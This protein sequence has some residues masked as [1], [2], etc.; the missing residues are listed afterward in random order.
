MQAVCSSVACKQSSYIALYRQHERAQTW[1]D[2]AVNWVIEEGQDLAVCVVREVNFG[3]SL[4]MMP[5]PVQSKN[6]IMMSSF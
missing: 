3:P 5:T 6:A 2:V 1:V 4:V